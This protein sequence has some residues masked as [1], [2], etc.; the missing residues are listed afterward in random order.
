MGGRN[1]SVTYQ[2]HLLRVRNPEFV[3]YTY[4]IVDKFSKEAVI[5]DPAWEIDLI[6]DKIA[7]LN[8]KLHK[9][10]LTH[11]HFD[12]V[13]LA[14]ILAN[15]YHAQVYI[16]AV[17]QAYYHFQCENLNVVNHLDNIFIGKTKI[18]C[19]LTPG[20][21]AGG[22]CFLLEKSL[23]TGDTIF[24]EGCGMCDGGGGS[25]KEMFKSIQMVKKVINPVVRIFPGHSFGKV[26][27]YTLKYLLNKNIYFQIEQ[28]EHFI[29][30]RLRKNQ[31]NIFSFQ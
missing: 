14:E 31:N 27:G 21:T 1:V 5:V 8:V 28:E 24:I 11:S 16:S 15:R 3:N 20:H 29:N 30:F 23:F 12:H 10:L 2:V 6:L 25:A 22:M 17:E 18:T 13:N 9:I 26:P 19:L 7:H 4:I